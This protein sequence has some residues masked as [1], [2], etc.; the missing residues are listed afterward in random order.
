MK[1]YKVMAANMY[2]TYRAGSFVASSKGEAIQM[3]KDR[4]RR[5][6]AGRTMKDVGAFR[7]Y[8]VN[9]WPDG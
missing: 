6:E 1:E 8:T 7:F 5:S 2:G 9:E 3:A 4:Y